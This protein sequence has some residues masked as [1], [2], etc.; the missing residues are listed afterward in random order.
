M[1]RKSIFLVLMA[2]GL[3]W[4]VWS[5]IFGVKYEK[6]G[7]AERQIVLKFDGKSQGAVSIQKSFHAI[8]QGVG[9]ITAPLGVSTF[10]EQY[11]ARPVVLGG[12]FIVIGIMACGVLFV[13]HMVR[14]DARFY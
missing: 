5:G 1:R 12:F 8:S 7:S 11:R 14:S 10:V 6:K 3:A 9:K 4:A 13:I 2:L